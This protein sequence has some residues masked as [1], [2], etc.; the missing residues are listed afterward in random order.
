M[1]WVGPE[2]VIAFWCSDV[3]SVLLWHVER[4]GELQTDCPPRS[5]LRGLSDKSG[6]LRYIQL[7]VTLLVG[8]TRRSI[9]GEAMFHCMLNQNIEIKW[10]VS[11]L[12]GL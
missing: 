11:M 3:T 8:E 9:S 2:D 1:I 7:T 10:Y 6:S 12:L 5:A 4:A